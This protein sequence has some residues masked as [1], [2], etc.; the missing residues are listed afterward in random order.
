MA[1]VPAERQSQ[2]YI[3][4]ME[5]LVGFAQKAYDRQQ[6]T[7]AEPGGPAY[8]AARNRAAGRELTNAEARDAND[9]ANAMMRENTL[10]HGARKT[11]RSRKNRRQSRKRRL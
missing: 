10:A 2:A 9:A 4:L 1:S 11:R 8:L 5:T 3:Y 6:V 7:F